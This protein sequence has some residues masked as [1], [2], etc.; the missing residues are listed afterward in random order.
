MTTSPPRS[1]LTR[2]LHRF[3]MLPALTWWISLPTPP[4]PRRDTG[5]LPTCC[6]TQWQEEPADLQRFRE[7]NHTGALSPTCRF[8]TL[9]LAPEEI[10]ATQEPGQGQGTP[11]PRVCPTECSSST[12]RSWW[13]LQTEQWLD[14]NPRTWFLLHLAIQSIVTNIFLFCWSSPPFLTPFK[15][16][17]GHLDKLTI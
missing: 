13:R 8:H 5:I 2:E 11:A 3:L 1:F 4:Q 14:T 15:S 17:W 6:Y 10:L 16:P 12:G 9:L 7:L